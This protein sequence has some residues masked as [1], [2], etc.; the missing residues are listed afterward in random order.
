MLGTRERLCR[1][2]IAGIGE[3]KTDK[4]FK[5]IPPGGCHRHVRHERLLGKFSGGRLT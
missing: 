1:G 5:V 4:K 2:T 3:E